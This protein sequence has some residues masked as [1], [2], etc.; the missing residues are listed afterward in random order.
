MK[1]ESENW[2]Q[3]Q[4]QPVAILGAGISGNGVVALLKQLGWDYGIYDE[5]GRAFTEEEARGCSVIVCSPGFK[6]EH[7]WKLIAQQCGKK[8]ITETEFGS[9]FTDAKIIAVTGTNGKTTLATFLAH[10]WNSVNRPA[11]AAGNVGL[12]LSQAVADG[13]GSDAIIF[14][15][16]SS[17]QAEDMVD[18]KPEGVL[19]TNFD[20][21]HI[22]HHGTEEKY[23]YAKAKLLELVKNGQVMIGESVHRF[24]LKINHNLPI[25]TQ[26]I[27][28]NQA[29]P[30]RVNREHFL[31]TY[32]QAENMAIAREF[33]SRMGISKDQ[34]LQ[35]VNSY[36]SEP[37]RLQ[38]IESFGNA[39]FWNDSK[40]TN[41]LSAIAA[42]KNFS[43]N[44]FWI[45]GGRSKGGMVG[46]LADQLKPL[47]Q[48]AFLFGESG[49]SLVKAFQA[50]GLPGTF[51]N[52]LEEAV[53]KAFSAVIEKT[54]ILFSP[55]FASFDCFK[56]Y[57]DR[58]NYFV[59]CV[60]D[61]KKISSMSTHNTSLD[62]V[63]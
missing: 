17:F 43:G 42:C 57:S 14:L 46:G 38:K 30:L 7:P 22:D 24:A 15:E 49:K 58:G 39:T 52:S 33:S 20:L 25:Q 36:I 10:L 27:R 35:A 1:R 40:S 5:Q 45:G 6:K 9:K 23:F 31:S 53:S 47:I 63:H 12:P 56:N 18:L 26:I 48:K 50:N 29:V 59:K 61:L 28:R 62:F 51:C 41:F 55:G 32:P 2:K 16:T 34:F 8:V 4:Q 44:L 21:D 11:V 19:W 37:H 3:W 60:L 54:D 13:L